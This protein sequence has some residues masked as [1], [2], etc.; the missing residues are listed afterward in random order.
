M[1]SLKRDGVLLAYDDVGSGA[2]PLLL[3]HGYACDR[4]AM[5]RQAAHF[6]PAHRVVSVDLRGH[7]E[8][9]KPEGCYTIPAFA[10]DLAWLCRELGLYR[11]VVVGH[12][13]G[14]M[15]ALDLAARYPDLAAAIVALDA[16]IVPPAS[17]GAMLGPVTEGLRGPAYREVLKQFLG[18]AFSPWDD[19]GRK[20]RILAACDRLP[21]HVVRSTWLDGMLTWD[22]EAAVA[23]CSTPILYV[24]SGLPN[25][26]LERF[27]EPCPHLMTGQTVGAGHFH[28][29]EVPDQVNPMIDRFL[30]IVA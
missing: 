19:P 7:G 13:L 29:L 21:E 10:D 26:D 24:D 18:A 5:A 28:Q 25:C 14:G 9:D 4:S 22:S 30:T 3:V 27:R 6:A 15:I 1:A 12:S 17:T 2:P 20:A 23:A 11:P 8:S 16:T